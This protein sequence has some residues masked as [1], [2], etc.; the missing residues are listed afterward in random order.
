MG[1]S[2]LWYFTVK[3]QICLIDRIKQRQNRFIHMFLERI[4]L[5]GYVFK[6]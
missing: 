5:K 4:G 2:G 1:D 6:G 3:K